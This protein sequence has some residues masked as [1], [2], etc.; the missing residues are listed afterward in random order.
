MLGWLKI[1][2]YMYR[3]LITTWKFID[4]LDNL[5][6]LNCQL[7]GTLL[8]YF[9]CTMSTE[10]GSS[11]AISIESDVYSF[12]ILLLEIFFGRRP[13]DSMFC[14]E[15]SLRKWVNKAHPSAVLEIIDCKLLQDDIFLKQQS[16]DRTAIQHCLISMINVGLQCSRVLPKERTLMKDVIP[17][18]QQIKKEYLVK[19]PCAEK[20]HRDSVV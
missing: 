11:G 6:F 9:M 18:L 8:I 4:D 10:Y 16:E 1:M 7:Y 20:K 5:P 14:G 19:F 13:T 15:L 2:L 3:V 17:I 12:G